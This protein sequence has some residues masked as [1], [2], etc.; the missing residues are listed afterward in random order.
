MS[1]QILKG[2][3]KNYIDFFFGKNLKLNHN[4]E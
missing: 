1:L 3:N 2:Y 4:L